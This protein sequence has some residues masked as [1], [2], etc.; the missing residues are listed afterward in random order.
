MAYIDDD[1]RLTMPGF[2]APGIYDDP[3][4]RTGGGLDPNAQ[5]QSFLSYL[6]GTPYPNLT[7]G[8]GA[9]Q[10]ISGLL[11]QY[12][13]GAVGAGAPITGHYAPGAPSGQP[14]AGPSIIQPKTAGGGD[15]GGGGIMKGPGT[16]GKPQSFGPR[17]QAGPRGWF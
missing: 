9:G 15:A 2:M 4:R 7:G 1:W 10:G 13:G 6:M 5:F 12:Y 8:P 11:G 3:R 14:T 16:T 17:A